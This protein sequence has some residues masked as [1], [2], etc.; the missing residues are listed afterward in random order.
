[1]KNI[2]FSL[3]KTIGQ[4]LSGRGLGNYSWVGA[5]YQALFRALRPRG[6]VEISFRDFRLRVNATDPGIAPWLLMGKEFSPA[7]VRLLERL[8]KPGMAFVDVGANIGYFSLLAAK[9][10]GPAGRVYA[11]E[12]DEENFSLLQQNI[13]LNNL[14]NIVAVKKGISDKI[15][16]TILYRD[17]ENPCRHSLAPKPNGETV[18][19]E[20]TTLDNF[21]A[22]LGQID[23]I[24]VDVEG[25]EPAVLQGMKKLVQI[26]PRLILLTEFYPQAINKFGSSPEKYLNDLKKL[27]FSLFGISEDR[28]FQPVALEQIKKLINLV[29]L[30]G[31]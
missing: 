28:N 29:G 6:I 22:D 25:A 15:G 19:I 17:L 7:E 11:F 31:Y 4:K 9:L 1:M 3:F 16:Q 18:M 14:H 2:L 10:V 24:K 26:N 30:K 21:F 23:F 27:D 20:T 13:E 12:P 5:W 8:L